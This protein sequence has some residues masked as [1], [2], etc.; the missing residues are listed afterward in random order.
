MGSRSPHAVPGTALV[1]LVA[2]AGAT[3]ADASRQARAPDIFFAP[4][5]PAVVD[6]MLQLA[7]VTPDDVVYDLGSGDGR[8]LMRAAQRY[9]ARGVGIELDPRL[10]GL[11]TVIA[12]EGGVA[13]RVTF[14]EGD[15]FKV[16]L[17]PAS[18]VTLYL[19]LGIN[20]QLQPK[21]MRELRPGA[22]VVS[23][24]FEIGDWPPDEVAVVDGQRIFLWTVRAR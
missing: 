17:S 22:R 24:T 7:R 21:L 18:V 9:G 15:L 13:D 19:S 6:A 14:I 10:V 11:A 2:L 23:N 12:R 3:A 20:R 4:T 5:L 8:I 1:L 16:N